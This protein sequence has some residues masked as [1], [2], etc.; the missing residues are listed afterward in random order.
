MNTKN[1]R[2]LIL[3][4]N[5]DG[6]TA[7][8]LKEVSGW[9]QDLGDVVV[10]APDAPRSGQSSA[11]TANQPLRLTPVTERP[12]YRAYQTNG[13]PVDCIK[14]S[15]HTVLDRKPDM[16]VSGIN[17]GSNA[18]ISIL[19]SGTMGAVLEGCVQDIPS[20]GFSLCSHD[21]D[22]DFTACK[23]VVG[24]ICR[25]I[26][27]EGLPQGVCLNINIPD[28]REIKGIKVCR[29]AHGYWTEEYARR[30]DPMG[31]DY[32]WLTGY[33]KNLEPD[34]RET[35]EWAL[36]HDYISLVPCVADMTAKQY[37]PEFREWLTR[38]V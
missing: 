21:P 25:R 9:L 15:M 6:I 13:T 10:V 4:T 33:F 38:T 3:V 11:I 17:H 14:L 34:N 1:K 8:G 29:Q 19:Y 16:I 28:V 36:A 2:P 32:F 27:E 23:P 5:D 12:G 31:K 20:V 24:D 30:T 26:W 18:G 37:I 35:D 7:K 22:A